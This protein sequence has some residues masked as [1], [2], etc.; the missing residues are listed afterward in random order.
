MVQLVKNLPVSAGDARDA[1]RIPGLG[2]SSGGG[3]GNPLQYSCLENSTDRGAWQDIDRGVAKR[4]DWAHIHY[5]Y[6]LIFYNFTII[7][8][9]GDFFTWIMLELCWTS[10]IYVS[11]I[12][13]WKFL[14]IIFSR[15]ALTHCPSFWT[16]V[17]CVLAFWAWFTC[18]LCSP[19]PYF[20]SV[21]IGLCI[22]F[23]LFITY[24]VICHSHSAL[25][26]I[27]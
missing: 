22:F 27:Q 18:S 1:G 7:C 2:R 21:C 13:F 24:H 10:S 4:H 8:L 16:P 15:T 17:T 14:A 9:A 12:R 25:R 3:N 6:A 23:W 20:S 5:T 26:S 19:N 11:F